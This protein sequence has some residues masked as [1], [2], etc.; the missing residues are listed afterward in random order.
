MEDSVDIGELQIPA[1]Y[2]V[3]TKRQKKALCNK[4]IESLL[5]AIE[6]NF[7]PQYNRIDILDEMLE[8]SIIT[9]Q[10]DENYEIC[11]VLADVKD[12]LNSNE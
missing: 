7:D 9:N 10:E 5:I 12:L 6:K 1:N 2:F 11:Q 3:M 8:S 4:I